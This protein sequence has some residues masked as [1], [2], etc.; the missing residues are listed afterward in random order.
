MQAITADYEGT[1]PRVLKDVTTDS[2]PQCLADTLETWMW[3][4]YTTD[5]IKHVQEKAGRPSNAPALIPLKLRKKSIMLLIR[6]AKLWMPDI[7]LFKMLWEKAA[8]H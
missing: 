6:E 7:D 1:K 4:R 2:I 3:K 8:S 5:E